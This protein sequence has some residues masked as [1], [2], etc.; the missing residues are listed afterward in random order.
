MVLVDARISG[1]ITGL[2]V[3]DVEVEP[4]INAELTGGIR[5][6]SCSGRRIPMI[7]VAAG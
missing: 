3:N 2:T 7:F 4:L 1:L 6:G 5:S